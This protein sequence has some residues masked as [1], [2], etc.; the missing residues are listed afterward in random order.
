M[1]CG[2]HG[3]GITVRV[4]KAGAWC[5]GVLRGLNYCLHEYLQIGVFLSWLRLRRVKPHLGSYPPDYGLTHRLLAFFP[6]T[7]LFSLLVQAKAIPIPGIL[8]VVVG[9]AFGWFI[10]RIGKEAS[11]KKL[12]IASTIILLFIAG[13]I[14]K[15]SLLQAR[16][17]QVVR[18]AATNSIR[19]LRFQV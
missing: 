9:L 13:E 3:K 2:A 12:L 10:F 17:T 15:V 8:G 11:L 16:H 6:G 14:W 7:C 4:V 5:A 1:L 19:A 18:T